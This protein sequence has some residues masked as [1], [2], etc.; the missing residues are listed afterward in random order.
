[1]K[2]REDKLAVRTLEKMKKEGQN[3]VNDED[4]SG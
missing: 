4:E 3:L 2:S 1:M